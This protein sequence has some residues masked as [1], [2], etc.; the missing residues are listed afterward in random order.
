MW[1][2]LNT[3]DAFAVRSLKCQG[4]LAGFVRCWR[5]GDDVSYDELD[6]VRRVFDV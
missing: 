5:Y 3:F 1:P 2:T 4:Q 6:D